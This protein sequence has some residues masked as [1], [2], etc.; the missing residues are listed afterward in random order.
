MSKETWSYSELGHNF[1]HIVKKLAIH[2]SVSDALC[3]I[4]G[5]GMGLLNN[6]I[7]YEFSQL[8]ETG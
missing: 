2:V 7:Q 4:D 3:A 8:Q 6:R 1:T 5:I